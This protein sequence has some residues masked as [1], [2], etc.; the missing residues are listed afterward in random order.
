MWVKTAASHRQNGSN[1]KI[2]IV[3]DL[4]GSMLNTFNEPIRRVIALKFRL[5]FSTTIHN[6][7]N[8]LAPVQFLLLGRWGTG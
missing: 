4:I 3:P 1:S 8:Q 2:T 7:T 6:Q 5:P